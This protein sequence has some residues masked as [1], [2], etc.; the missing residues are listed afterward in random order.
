[1]CLLG[2][3][4]EPETHLTQLST[5]LRWAFANEAVQYCVALAVVLTR[6][7]VAFVPLAFTMN[8]HKPWG[9]LT[10]VTPL[11]LLGGK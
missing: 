9:T 5:K 3:R 8:A 10:V 6:S 4:V 11:S 1:M 2:G 7:V